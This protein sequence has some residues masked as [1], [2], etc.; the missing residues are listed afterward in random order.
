MMEGRCLNYRIQC[1][2]CDDDGRD[3]C[4]KKCRLRLLTVPSIDY[5]CYDGYCGGDEACLVAEI[6]HAIFHRLNDYGKHQ[7]DQVMIQKRHYNG[8]YLYDV[9]GMIVRM[10]AV[11]VAALAVALIDDN[12]PT[13]LMNNNVMA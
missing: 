7:S 5:D 1:S 6:V 4:A 3:D 12:E 11:V 8:K 2:L 13:I 9:T 10:V